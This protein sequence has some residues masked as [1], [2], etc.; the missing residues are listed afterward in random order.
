MNPY[1]T[2]AWCGL[3]CN[4]G[5]KYHNVVHSCKMDGSLALKSAECPHIGAK[6]LHI[7]RTIFIYTAFVQ[8]SH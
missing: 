8:E 2:T 5:V 1:L 4:V 3:S 7:Y 6:Q